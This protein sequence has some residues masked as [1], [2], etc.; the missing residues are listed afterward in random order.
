V[1]DKAIRG[2]R[3]TLLGF[4]S[5]RGLLL[6]T[7]LL[8]ARLLVPSDFGVVAFAT[9]AITLLTH[10]TSLGIP[11]AMVVRHDLTKRGLGTVLS[12]VLVL[13]VASAAILALASPLVADVFGDS[14]VRGV[15]L[16]LCIPVAFSGL[17]AFYWAVLQRELEFARHFACQMASTATYAIVAITLAVLDAGVWSIVV[18]QI[19]S[20]AVYAVALIL[21]APWRVWPSF[22]PVQARQ[23]WKTGRGFVMQG[24]FSFVQQNTDYF[25]VGSALGSNALGYYSMAYKLSELPNVA[26]GEPVA[27]VTFPSFARMKHRSEEI[28]ASFLGVLRLV[29]LVVCPL[30]ILLAATADPF[31]HAVLGDKWLAMIGPLSVLGI[32][33]AIRPVQAT[34]AWMLNS[35]GHAGRIGAVYA[36]VLLLTVPLLVLA[37]NLGGVTAVSWVMVGDITIALFAVTA[38]M[39]RRTEVDVRS[40]ARAVRPIALACPVAWAVAWGAAHALDAAP[41]FVTL[42]AS[43]AAGAAVYLATVSWTDPG[44]VRT[45]TR[46][47]RRAM[48]R[49]QDWPSGHRAGA[50]PH[51]VEEEVTGALP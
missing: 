8:L 27:E 47:V 29:A 35:T 4:F 6:A 15:L 24:G 20:G 11:Q 49:R 17:S 46:Q 41:A 43:A 28:S 25:I 50:E 2:V 3:W 16:A 23:I 38:I 5:N 51:L 7:T 12:M 19:A 33:G 36:V 26:L 10:V 37:A 13:Y 39:H 18:G 32:W 31:V 9:L 21:A 22:D 1:E 42:C 48:R 14:R 44:I 45:A 34:I 40:A 30:G